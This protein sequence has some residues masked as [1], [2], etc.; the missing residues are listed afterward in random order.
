MFRTSSEL[1]LR[2]VALA[3]YNPHL[4]TIAVRCSQGLVSPEV[5]LSGTNISG[6]RLTVPVNR[7]RSP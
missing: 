3:G 4:E 1:Y 2:D 7:E 6:R 5:A